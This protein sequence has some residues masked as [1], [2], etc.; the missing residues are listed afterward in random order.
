MADATPPPAAARP[1]PDIRKWLP[2]AGIAVALW[3]T[4]PKYSGPTLNGPELGNPI[5]R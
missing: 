3:A 2:W 4:L 1:E 5:P